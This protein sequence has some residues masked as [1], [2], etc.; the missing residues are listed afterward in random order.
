MPAAIPV[1]SQKNAEAVPELGHN[2]VQTLLHRP[3]ASRQIDYERPVSDDG[4]RPGKHGS[5]GDLQ[6]FGPDCRT[7]G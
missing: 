5:S 4:H 2:N 7:G 1:P 3:A 6:G